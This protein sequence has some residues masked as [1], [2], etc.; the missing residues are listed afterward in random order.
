RLLNHA[1]YTDALPGSIIKPIMATGFLSDPKYRAKISAEKVSPAFLRL[2]D[3]LKSSD[4]VAFLNRMFCADKGWTNCDRPHAIQQAALKFGWDVGC[5]EGSFRCGR[6]NVL[7]GHAD[8]GR[9]RQDTTRRPLG[10]S[11]MYGRVLTEPASPKRP[12]DLQMMRD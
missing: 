12:G 4:S 10:A 11:I 5:E 2:Q 7:F 9:V 6:L 1:L 3:E 8:T